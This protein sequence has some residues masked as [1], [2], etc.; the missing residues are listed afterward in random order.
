[1]LVTNLIFKNLPQIESLR[2]FEYCLKNDISLTYRDL[3]GEKSVSISFASEGNINF[4]ERIKQLPIEDESFLKVVIIFHKEERL[5]EFQK[6]MQHQPRRKSIK[7]I[8]LIERL[9]DSLKLTIK[10]SSK[11]DGNIEMEFQ[12]PYKDFD[13]FELE[14]DNNLDQEIRDHLQYVFNLSN[15]ERQTQDHKLFEPKDAEE[16]L[17]EFLKNIIQRNE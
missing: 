14:F 15:E 12:I 9:E 16:E 3:M 4:I 8:T 11:C 2:L 7:L 17:K 5:T 13:N 6:L 10:A 1:M